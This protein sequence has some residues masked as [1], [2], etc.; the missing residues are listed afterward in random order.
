MWFRQTNRQLPCEPNLFGPDNGRFCWVQTALNLGLYAPVMGQ[1]SNEK[2]MYS[3]LRNS[4][5][6][7]AR[8]DVQYLVQTAT[9]NSKQSVMFLS[10]CK[11]YS[12][13]EQYDMVPNGTIHLNSVY[14]YDHSAWG[15]SNIYICICIGTYDTLRTNLSTVMSRHILLAEK[16]VENL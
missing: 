5:F 3:Y 13:E 15:Q 8:M 14:Q 4:R 12:M 2:Q 6:P 10:F 7:L 11:W 1:L 9:R 16:L